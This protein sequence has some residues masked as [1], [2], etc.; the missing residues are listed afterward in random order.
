MATECIYGKLKS[1]IKC[2]TALTI[3]LIVLLE[4]KR[5]CN[6]FHFISS[7]Y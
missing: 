7:F 6:E 5:L 1:C 3:I 4:Q 2:E